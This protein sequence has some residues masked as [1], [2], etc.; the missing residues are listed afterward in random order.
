MDQT[1]QHAIE[2][3][4]NLLYLIESRADEAEDVRRYVEIA[5]QPLDVLI[6]A[7]KLG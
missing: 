1:S 2:I 3:L 5:R 6:E 7:A 4:A